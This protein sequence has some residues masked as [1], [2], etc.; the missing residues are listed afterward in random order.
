MPQYGSNLFFLFSVLHQ[1]ILYKSG[2]ADTE[3]SA[4]LYW[5]AYKKMMLTTA[6]RFSYRKVHYLN[7][8]KTELYWAVDTSIPFMG[9]EF[10][11]QLV[12][13]LLLLY[14]L[15]LYCSSFPNTYCDICPQIFE[16]IFGCLPS[17]L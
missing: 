12:F 7:S 17:T 4:T 10:V 15:L 16:T 11:V 6:K 13:C 8:Y 2:E 5:L 9:P 1:Q 14:C 3:E